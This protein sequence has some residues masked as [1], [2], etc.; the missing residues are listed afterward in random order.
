MSRMGHNRDA[1]SSEAGFADDLVALIGEHE[2]VSAEMLAQLLSV[3]GQHG[4]S[5]AHQLA[6]IQKQLRHLLDIGR[7][8]KKGSRRYPLWGRVE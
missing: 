6:R 1:G 3:Q 4:L 8:R 5:T 2:P 7:I